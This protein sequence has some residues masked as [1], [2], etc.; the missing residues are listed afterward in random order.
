MK[1]TA[2]P[3]NR[4]AAMQGLLSEILDAAVYELHLDA[5][6]FYDTFAVSEIAH[7]M[8]KGDIRLLDELKSKYGGSYKTLA[9]SIM[10][11]RERK[12]G[13]VPVRYSAGNSPEYWAGSMLAFYQWQSCI[14]FAE[15]NK[16][17]S[18][19]YVKGMHDE[20]KQRE[21]EA[22]AA[23]ISTLFKGAKR[24][25]NLATIRRGAG[26]SQ[27]QLAEAADIPVRTIQQYEQR[28]KNINKAQAEYI[29]RMARVLGCKMD[30]L[31][32]LI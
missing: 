19:E 15:I 4:L 10:A 32:E 18:I 5:T 9:G 6:E 7:R 30:D 23:T 28:Q 24:D 3:Q 17:L 8:E 12:V 26:F 27:K 31:L 20:F 1:V 11:G 25:T 2:Y 16:Y 13:Q 22:F 21:P 14:P 29:F